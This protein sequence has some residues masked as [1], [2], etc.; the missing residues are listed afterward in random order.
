[1]KTGLRKIFAVV[2]LLV[3]G[4]VMGVAALIFL[5]KG[6]LNE[7]E[8]K[9]E[10]VVDFSVREQ[11]RLGIECHDLKP[12][13]SA[14]LQQKISPLISARKEGEAWDSLVSQGLRNQLEDYDDFLLACVRLYNIGDAGVL[15]G[16][17]DLAFT[18]TILKAALKK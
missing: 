9:K 14:F 13:L 18:Q 10:Y 2:G 3:S 16:L 4:A 11:K 1:M 7:E 15:N 12:K 8:R 5:Q 17:Q 6:Q